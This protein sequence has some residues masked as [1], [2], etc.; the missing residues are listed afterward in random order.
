ML[1]GMSGLEGGREEEL[2]QYMIFVTKE[3]LYKTER[4][5]IT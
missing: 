1:K 2:H 4:Q 3:A 5:I